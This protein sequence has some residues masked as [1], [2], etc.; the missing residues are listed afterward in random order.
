M[1]VAE[2]A[3]DEN[4][5]SPAAWKSYG[6]TM[7]KELL[8]E[9]GLRVGEVFIPVRTADGLRLTRYDPDLAEVLESTRDFMRRH[10]GAMRALA[11]R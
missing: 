6:L 4:R 11:K 5:E 10:A 9:L 3:D 8:E 7:S 1:A 2:F